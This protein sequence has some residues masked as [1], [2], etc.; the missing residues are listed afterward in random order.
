MNI[1]IL[2]YCQKTALTLETFICNIFKG[3]L[4]NPVETN[5]RSGIKDKLSWGSGPI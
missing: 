5:I 1:H 2:V 3:L 4:E